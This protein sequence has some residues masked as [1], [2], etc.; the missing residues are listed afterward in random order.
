M[1]ETIREIMREC[2]GSHLAGTMDLEAADECLGDILG[3]VYDGDRLAAARKAA[4]ALV[5]TVDGWDFYAIMRH[6]GVLLVDISPSFIRA[7]CKDDET[8]EIDKAFSWV[9]SKILSV[10]N[11]MYVVEERA[12][13]N[14]SP[15]ESIDILSGDVSDLSDLVLLEAILIKAQSWVEC[16]DD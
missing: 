7:A 2:A 8:M 12:V 9:G 14:A 6:M 1:N 13:H 3:V 4:E 5:Y 15:G 16:V 11:G 10:F